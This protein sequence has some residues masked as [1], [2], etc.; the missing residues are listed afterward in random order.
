MHWLHADLCSWEDVAQLSQFVKTESGTRTVPFDVILDKSTSDAIAT[1]SSREFSSP[2]PPNAC[3]T[4]RQLVEKS[5]SGEA[6]FFPVELVALHL[7]L[8]TRKGTIWVALSYSSARFDGLPYLSD[9][10]T[11]LSR[12]T[13]QAPSGQA[14]S[15]SAYVPQIFHW[16]YILQRK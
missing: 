8:L 9:Y 6:T 7:A 2:V 3:P 5:E 4:V 1:S 15:S 11:V 16:V 10:W 14:T 12:T 13:V